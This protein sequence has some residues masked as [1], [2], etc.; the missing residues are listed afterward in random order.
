MLADDSLEAVSSRRRSSTH[1]E[2]AKRALE[3]GK[4]VLVEKP[5][6]LTRRRGRGA[7]RDSPRSGS[8]ADA[9]PPAA[10]PPGV[11]A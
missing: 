9:G 1:C 2:L 6:A 7:R 3:A 11:V 5:P 4:H 10:L 8:R